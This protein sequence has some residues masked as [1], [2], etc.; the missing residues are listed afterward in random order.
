M[1]STG[2]IGR[3][4]IDV[5]LSHPAE[6]KIIGLA[7]NKS[8]SDLLEQVRNV[9]PKYVCVTD[10]KTAA[11]VAGGP[12]TVF[13]SGK[14]GLA[15]IAAADEADVVLNAVVGSA[16]LTA[17]LAAIEAGKTLAL[18]NKES[19]VAAGGLVNEALS[20]SGALMIPVD[21]EHNALFQCLRG[22][23]IAEV[24]RLILTASGGP[25]RGRG[26]A[27][28]AGVTPAEALNHPRWRMGRRVTIDSA[29][30]MNK[31]FEVIEAHWLFGLDFDRIEVIIH[32][33]SIVH[34]MVEFVDKS[35]KAHLGPTDMRLPILYSLS[36]P[37]RL[38]SPLEALDLARMGK[39]EFFE[40]EPDKNIC[41]KLALDAGRTGLSYPTALNG[42]DEAAVA[43]F[44]AGEIG[45][46]EIGNII[47]A[48]LQRHEQVPIGSVSDFEMVDGWSK[49]EAARVIEQIRQRS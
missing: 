46:N 35:I 22:E 18:A 7:A 38:A 49:A 1:G 11:A 5:A 44:L 23:D 41:L 47:D 4:A 9:R 24:S 13:L 31:G 32:P 2:S 48:V 27:D 37:K 28:M 6:F 14:A 25:F 33:Q 40:A 10:D 21:S 8:A 20:R 29:T 43:A 26:P 30:L 12:N 16:G 42:A 36:W 3:Q 15:E 45:F 17:T 19:L 39:L 34:S